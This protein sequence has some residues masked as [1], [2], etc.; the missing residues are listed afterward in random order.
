MRILSL[1]THGSL[2]GDLVHIEAIKTATLSFVLITE[3]RAMNDLGWGLFG[4][5]SFTKGS[6]QA[7]AR[8]LT[9]LEFGFGG[10][11]NVC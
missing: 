8:V 1:A 11:C 4:R 3:N 10:P 5:R 9:R 6:M 7:E 2:I